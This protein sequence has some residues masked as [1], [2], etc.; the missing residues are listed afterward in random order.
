[1]TRLEEAF[2]RFRATLTLRPGL[3]QQV[4]E[5]SDRLTKILR[6]GERTPEII[7]TGSYA[8]DT[9]APPLDD[10]DVMFIFGHA[11]P[12]SSAPL[13]TLRH[14]HETLR[15]HYAG[16]RLQRR[17]IGIEFKD[18]GFSIDVVPAF[19]TSS[20]YQ[21]ADVD[22]NDQTKPARW[23]S[24]NPRVHEERLREANRRTNGLAAALVATLKIINRAQSPKLKSFHLEAMTLDAI[25]AG[26]STS[27]GFP[28]ALL[29][30]LEAL[31]TGVERP[32]FDRAA[33]GVALDD[34]LEGIA[35][36]EIAP[37]YRNL[38]ATLREAIRRD[39]VSIARTLLP[40]LA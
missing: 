33:P 13:D 15:V 10:I 9:V 34:Y 25:D 35:R 36:R 11:G 1:M 37:R 31:A 19:K 16:A 26:L 12:T 8:R 6:T 5:R 24:T 7:P 2:Q 14:V 21:I 18:G 4:T 20:G 30:A 3:E 17:S 40:R 28:H 32:C 27:Q 39:E 29:G 23:I 38:A 22:P